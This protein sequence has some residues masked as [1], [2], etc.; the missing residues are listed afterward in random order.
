MIK[1]ENDIPANEVILHLPAEA[2][3]EKTELLENIEIAE[4]A[5][6]QWRISSL[7]KNTI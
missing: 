1:I 7:K 5:D 4:E 3:I 2:K 6:S